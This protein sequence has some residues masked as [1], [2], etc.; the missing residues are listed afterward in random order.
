MK[1]LYSNSEKFQK[2][3]VCTVYALT[4]SCLS[5]EEVSLHSLSKR[6]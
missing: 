2:C 3:S 5:S 4:A 1:M 6:Q